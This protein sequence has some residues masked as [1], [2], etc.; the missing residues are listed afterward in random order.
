MPSSTNAPFKSLESLGTIIWLS[1][2]DLPEPE[3]PVIQVNVP[4]GISTFKDLRLFCLAPLTLKN[5]PLPTL[6]AIGT[7]MLYSPDKYLPV[8][9]SSQAI[10]S[11]T[12]P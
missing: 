9:D 10:M 5:L 12:V 11:S 4:K 2:D 1:N 8:Y 3:T 6:L 7:G